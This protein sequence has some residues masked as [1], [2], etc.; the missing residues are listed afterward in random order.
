[1]TPPNNPT[2]LLE[3]LL[4]AESEAAKITGLK[5]CDPAYCLSLADLRT[6]INALPRVDEEMVARVRKAIARELD[7]DTLTPFERLDNA[8]KAAI[9]TLC[10]NRGRKGGH[11][12]KNGP[13]QSIRGG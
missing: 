4:E 5:D 3:R 9:S 2:P 10:V 7:R 12:H 11:S 6:I 8:A 1:V 13:T